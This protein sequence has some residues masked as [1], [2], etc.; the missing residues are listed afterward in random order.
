[1]RKRA[2][3]SRD[4]KVIMLGSKMWFIIQHPS[5]DSWG[6]KSRRTYIILFVALSLVNGLLD[7]SICGDR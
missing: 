4:H 6:V 7:S 2:L 3:V 1:M 5:H